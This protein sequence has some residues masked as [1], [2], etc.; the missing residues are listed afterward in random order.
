MTTTLSPL[1]DKIDVLSDYDKALLVDI[2]LKKIYVAHPEIDTTWADEALKRWNA[3]K[4]GK[5]GYVSYE[6]AMKKHRSK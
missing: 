3:Y 2:I 1:V 5:M 6:M 4:K